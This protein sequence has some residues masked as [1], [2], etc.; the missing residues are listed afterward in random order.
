MQFLI[1]SVGTG[2]KRFPLSHSE[3]LNPATTCLRLAKLPT[4][5]NTELTFTHITCYSIILISCRQMLVSYGN[6]WGQSPFLIG[7][8]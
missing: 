5:L 8:E 1:L 3:V 4:D 7:S 2:E 6:L